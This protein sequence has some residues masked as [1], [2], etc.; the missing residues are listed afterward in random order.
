MEQERLDR[1]YLKALGF[2]YDNMDEDDRMTMLYSLPYYD[3]RRGQINR[4]KAYVVL[5]KKINGDYFNENTISSMVRRYP[6]I[7]K[8]YLHKIKNEIIDC[9]TLAA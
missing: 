8:D 7:K 4:F 5:E 3:K 1:D 2:A 6:N 9:K